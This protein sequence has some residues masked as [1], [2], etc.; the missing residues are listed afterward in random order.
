MYLGP[1]QFADARRKALRRQ[2]AN[3]RDTAEP[4]AL[5]ETNLDRLACGID[6][7]GVT[8]SSKAA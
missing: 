1:E 7:R 2:R 3:A 6:S 5:F 8:S 4:H